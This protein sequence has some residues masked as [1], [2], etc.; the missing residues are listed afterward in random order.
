MNLQNQGCTNKKSM[1][2]T[3][4]HDFVSENEKCFFKSKMNLCV[5]PKNLEKGSPAG[6]YDETTV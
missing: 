3:R 1:Y 6:V 5:Y 2:S 4:N